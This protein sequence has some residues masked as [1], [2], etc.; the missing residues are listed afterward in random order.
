MSR[1]SKGNTG[2]NI[3]LPCLRTT[4]IPNRADEVAVSAARFEGMCRASAS[5]I[6]T[7]FFNSLPGVC[8]LKYVQDTLKWAEG[9]MLDT[10]QD[11]TFAGATDYLYA[12]G[13]MSLQPTKEWH[14]DANGPACLTCWQNFG[15]VEGSNLELC[16][17]IRGCIVRIN[18]GIG[19]FV[20][21]MAWL[22]HC[23]RL[24]AKRDNEFDSTPF[25]LH[26]TAYTKFRTE[27]A[28]YVLNE[29]RIRNL[30]L[31]IIKTK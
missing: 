10:G 8:A 6:S 29:Y 31:S 22:P 18:A 5:D 26:H 19:K 28:A 21:F 24:I 11:C 9:T 15:E 3:M 1:N 4:S 16:I 12:K 7:S 2:K 30:G 17:A 23:T 20:H 25:R 14:D 13:S 27:Y